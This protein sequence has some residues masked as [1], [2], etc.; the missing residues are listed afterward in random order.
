EKDLAA[1]RKYETALVKAE[2]NDPA[3]ESLYQ[4]A[5]TTWEEILPQAGNEMYRKQ[6][7]PR[8]AAGYLQLGELQLH[9]GKRAAAAAALRKAVDHGERAV[10]LEPDRPLSRH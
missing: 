6:A 2:Q 3:A 8:L 9:L 4:E 1:V 10:A 7:V 5:L